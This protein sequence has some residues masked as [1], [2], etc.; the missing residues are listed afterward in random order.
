MQDLDRARRAYLDLP[1][2]RRSRLQQLEVNKRERQLHVF[3]DCHRIQ[4][5]DIPNIGPGRKATLQSFGIETAAD[6]SAAAIAVIPGFGPALT[7]SL[8]SWRRRVEGG[9]AFNPTKG[10]DPADIA[11]IDRNIAATRARL[12]QELRGGPTRLQQIAQQ[13]QYSRQTL[14]T[15]VAA[16]RTELTR[17][18][19]DAAALSLKRWSMREVLPVACIVG[20]PCLAWLMWTHLA[21]PGGSGSPATRPPNF[22]GSPQPPQSPMLVPTQVAVAP[23][24]QATAA[25]TRRNVAPTL[26]SAAAGPTVDRRLAGQVRYIANTEQQGVRKRSECIE[27]SGVDGPPEGAAVTVDSARSDCPGWYWVRLASGELAWVREVYLSASPPVSPTVTSPTPPTA[28]TTRVP[29]PTRPS[30]SPTAT[31][32]LSPAVSGVGRAISRMDHADRA[33]LGAIQPHVEAL[34][35]AIAAANGQ[36]AAAGG[37]PGVVEDPTWRQGTEAAARQLTQAATGLRRSEPGPSTGAVRSYAVRAAE[38]ADEAARLLTAVVENR[39]PRSLTGVTTVLVQALAEINN[40]N[41][42]LVQLQS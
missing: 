29:A 40:M 33:Y 14:A 22:V 37:R 24:S 41:Q 35:K 2:Q 8:L 21:A 28:T 16:A 7:N 9:F 13:I 36:V 17:A 26:V 5:A 12:E 10:I 11:A 4:G 25:P 38:R 20:V 42:A 15:H 34:G 30:A 31:I 3:L 23:P 27:E 19:A 6:I 18:Q 39:D 1:Q 32:A